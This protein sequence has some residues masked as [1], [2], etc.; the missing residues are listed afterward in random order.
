MLIIPEKTL[1]FVLTGPY[2]PYILIKLLSR[3]KQWSDWPGLSHIALCRKKD[4][5]VPRPIWMSGKERGTPK[6]SNYSTVSKKGRMT[7]RENQVESTL[8]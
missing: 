7:V 2:L 1:D 3:R 6:Q 8:W 4:E 5:I